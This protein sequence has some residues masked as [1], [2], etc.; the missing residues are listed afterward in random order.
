MAVGVDRSRDRGVAQDLLE[1]L[2][3]L[4]RLDPERG[5]EVPDVDDAVHP[6]GTVVGPNRGSKNIAT[7][8]IYEIEL[9]D[10]RQRLATLF[11]LFKF[12]SEG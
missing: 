1:D 10:G 5:E 2:G 4:P 3:G 12:R 7:D 6:T 8:K 11:I 9:V